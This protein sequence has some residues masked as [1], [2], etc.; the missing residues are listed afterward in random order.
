MHHLIHAVLNNPECCGR[1][2]RVD[3]LPCVNPDGYELSLTYR[4]W[5]GNANHVDLNR[6]FGIGWG[7]G[8]RASDDET[9]QNFQGDGPESEAETK[10]I[11]ELLAVGGYSMVLDVHSAAA[12]LIGYI[13][14]PDMSHMEDAVNPKLM[15]ELMARRKM[16]QAGVYHPCCCLLLAVA[17][18]CYSVLLLL[19]LPVAVCCCCLLLLSVATAACCCCCCLLLSVVAVCHLCYRYSL[20]FVTAVATQCCCIS[21]LVH[22]TAAL[23]SAVDCVGRVCRVGTRGNVS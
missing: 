5:R 15:E 8:E 9:S 17:G 4:A 6:N 16:H 12:R 18:C 23:Q 3:F 13:P 20:L 11:S 19:L 14:S 2:T 22:L 10:L 7:N 1:N 21:L